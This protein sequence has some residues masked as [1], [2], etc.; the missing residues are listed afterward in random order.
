MDVLIL[1]FV[2]SGVY[3]CKVRKVRTVR[4]HSLSGKY[5]NF[6]CVL[7]NFNNFSSTTSILQRLICT[8]TFLAEVRPRTPL[9]ELSY[10]DP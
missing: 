3:P 2:T 6:S 4:T 9:G 10:D 1:V 5:V 7:S 8:K